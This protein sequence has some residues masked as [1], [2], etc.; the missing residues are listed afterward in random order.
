MILSLI[1]DASDLTKTD[2]GATL[3]ISDLA[4]AKWTLR[5]AFADHRVIAS[6]PDWS[7]DGSKVSENDAKEVENTLISFLS[8]LG[9]SPLDTWEGAK[10][11]IINSKYACNEP[12]QD[13]ILGSIPDGVP[14]VCVGSGPSAWQYIPL[15][16]AIQDRCVI[17]V[18]DSSYA[19][20]VRYGVI[21]DYVTMIERQQCMAKLVDP[22]THPLPRLVAPPI[23]HPDSVKGWEGR[24]I[25]WQQNTAGLYEWLCPGSNPADP[26]RSAGRS[27]GTLSIALAG[28]LGA[29]EIYL[30]GHD[31][32]R[33]GEYSHSKIADPM[34]VINHAAAVKVPTEEMHK[35]APCLGHDGETLVSCPFWNYVR[36]DI[37][38][39]AKQSQTKVYTTGLSAIPNVERVEYILGGN[40]RGPLP[41]LPEGASAIRD[42]SQTK[43]EIAASLAYFE[44]A[45]GGLVTDDK[46]ATLAKLNPRHWARGD[47]L[48][49]LNHILGTIYHAAGIRMRL[50][51]AEGDAGFKAGID[52]ITR[53]VPAM[54]CR[55][56]AE[57]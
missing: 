32:C 51:V 11:A 22:A 18:A 34:A 38:N 49:L 37:G 36:Q 53:T 56:E 21:P 1:P 33:S 47:S 4:K 10:N 35:D 44:D 57:L 45:V 5:N 14:V 27:A 26:H 43:A 15:L 12:T 9:N 6:L 24:R 54:L 52:I 19:G 55:M 20:L 28:A 16:R 7:V 42:R 31:L 25:W 23:V 29:K 46:A 39:W 40:V 2:S 17:I 13:A 30:V 8:D 48:P 50:R 3:G 41:P